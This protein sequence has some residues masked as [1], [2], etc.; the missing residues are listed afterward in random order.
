MNEQDKA[1]DQALLEEKDIVNNLDFDTHD[2]LKEVPIKS[3]I[4]SNLKRKTKFN[5]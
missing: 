1:N 2:K 3:G 5:L 4:L